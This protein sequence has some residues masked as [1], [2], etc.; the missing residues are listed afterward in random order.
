[1]DG[2]RSGGTA[3]SEATQSLSQRS[4]NGYKV[5]VIPFGLNGFD[6]EEEGA[7]LLWC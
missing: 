4:K 1:M 7:G 3:E 6:R 2:D 5:G